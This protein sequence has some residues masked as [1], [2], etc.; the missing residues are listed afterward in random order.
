VSAEEGRAAVL[1]LIGGTNPERTL[2]GIRERHGER[3]PLIR[4]P[5][6]V[7][8]RL[9]RKQFQ[10]SSIWWLL[11]WIPG[12]ADRVALVPAGA[13]PEQGTDE[14]GSYSFITCPCGARP[15]ARAQID[16]CTGCERYY[17]ISPD[18]GRVVVLYGDME[19]PGT[20]ASQ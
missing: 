9:G 18:G 4:D 5:S 11:R 1:A 12:L 15:V 2:E 14:L 13:V 19:I 10:R 16:K 3:P 20:P 7:Y 6:A 17:V 8:D